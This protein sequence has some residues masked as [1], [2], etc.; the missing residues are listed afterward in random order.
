MIRQ[1]RQLSLQR[2]QMLIIMLISTVSLLLA[3]AAFVYY[4]VSTYRRE[5]VDKIASLAEVVGNNTTAALDFGDPAAAGETLA[6]LRGSPQVVQAHLH[7]LDGELFATYLRKGNASVDGGPREAGAHH[8][9]TANHLWLVHP[10]TSGGEPVGNIELVADLDELDRRLWRYAGIVALVF[11]GSLVVA[12]FLSVRLGRVIS[13]PVR[14][15]AQV[16]QA[17]ARDKNYAV[18]ATKQSE[19]ELGLLIDG[20]NEMLT[21]IQQRDG[22]LQ[23]AREHL[24]QRVV[25]RT[26]ALAGSLSLLNATLEASEDGIVAMDLQG[27][28]TCHNAQFGKLWNFPTE[29][30]LRRDIQEMVL[31]AAARVK[32]PEAFT[33]RVRE[34]LAT[35]KREAFD[36]LEFKDGRVIE[37]LMRPQFVDDQCVGNVFSFRD[38]TERKRAETT[39]AAF[40]WMG[41]QLSCAASREEAA[42]IIS[43][44][45]SDLFG[46]DAFALHGYSDQD[47]LVRLI[48]EVDTIEGQRVA[49]PGRAPRSASALQR[50][51]FTSGAELILRDATT[52]LPGAMAFGNVSKP[53]ASLMFVPIRT[54][55]ELVGILSI[56]SYAPKAYTKQHL[57]TL[58]TLADHCGGALE[59]IKADEALRRTEELYRQAIAG[60]DAVPYCSNF[61]TRQYSFMGEGIQRL[62]GYAP[63]EVNGALWQNI[64][65]KSL[66][67]GEAAGLEK[68]EAAR[69][70]L[71]GHLR[72][73]RCDMLVTTRDG[74]SRWISDS[75]V[76]ELDATGKPLGS[77]GILQDITERKQAEAEL[78]YERDLLR[79]LLDGSPDHIY[80]K[81]LESRFIKTGRALAEQFGIT[82]VADL[83]GKT[84][85]DY[86]AEEHARPAFADEQ[87]II[88]TGVPVIDKVEKEVMPDGR[89]TWALTTKMPLR[90]NAGEIIGT[91]GI[92]K[93]ITG[94]KE[95][96]AQLHE[97]HKELLEVSR[98]AGM[99][100]V[101]TGVLHNVGNV[102]NS[103]NVAA[104]C[105]VENLRKSKAANLSKVVELLRDHE[106]DLGRFLTTDAKGKMIPGYLAQLAE[107]L[108]SEQALAE[109]ELTGLQQHIEHIKEIVAMQQNYARVCGVKE[110]I[111]ICDLVEDSLR[112]N[113]GALER[114]GVKL[115]RDFHDVPPLNVEK[116][117]I[118]QILVNLVRNAKYACDD[119]DRADKL[120]TV[121]VASDASCVKISVADNGVGIPPQNLTRIFGHGFTTRKGGH[122]FGLHSGALAAKE[123][124]GK[125]T[126]H[127][128]GPGQGAEFTLELPLQ[129]EGGM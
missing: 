98:Q 94:L 79:T 71:N 127:S 1:F 61:Q 32:D 123:M 85:F 62:I 117:K 28:M 56:Q 104:A 120:L 105:M 96:E 64:T 63:H 19:D 86:F 78:A 40:A 121:R 107:H 41:R 92:S 116:H 14:H 97:A 44:I 47:D 54:G 34:V 70:V 103:V 20:F 72:H 111:N 51:I 74:K 46:W 2:K 23:A 49:S 7:K 38:V 87:E 102:L 15:L 76:Q 109:K 90:N 30:I 25:E 29:V 58:Q 68:S 73:W 129:A 17:V 82:T 45:A 12:F 9:F 89:V 128:A 37:R 114:H 122:G 42:R 60:A 57:S 115:I 27:Q 8:F 91:F 35:P 113:L 67:L 69:Q 100:E 65:Q 118:L 66:M 80:F 77:M 59:R 88:R 101:A 81:D 126:A 10:V 6:A 18:R 106:S 99:A 108:A 24:E 48:F 50:R 11:G 3:C 83:E 52:F 55:N 36:V 93:N 112:M 75:S 53:S 125:L 95:T 43:E 84:D 39:A 110:I 21:Q 4:D 22:A 5:L 124:G 33:A 31:L 16:V 26:E 13:Q 119:A